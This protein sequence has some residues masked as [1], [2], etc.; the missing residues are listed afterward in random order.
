MS[1]RVKDE[2]YMTWYSTY[3]DIE[4]IIDYYKLTGFVV[5]KYS[6][7]EGYTRS[8]VLYQYLSSNDDYVCLNDSDY[9]GFFVKKSIV[10]KIK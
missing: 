8:S 5:D 2:I 3:S 10:D 6:K 1:N 9:Y 4:Q 7:F